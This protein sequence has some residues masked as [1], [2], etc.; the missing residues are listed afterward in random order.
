MK[1][2]MLKELMNAAAQTATFE[3]SERRLL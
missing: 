1:P 3:L 2:K